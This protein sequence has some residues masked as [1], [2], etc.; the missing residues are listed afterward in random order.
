[1]WYQCNQCIFGSNSIKLAT[2]HTL[3]TLHT[4]TKE[5]DK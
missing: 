3:E 5:N 1:M 4:I 2:T